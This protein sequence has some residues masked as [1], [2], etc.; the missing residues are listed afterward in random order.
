M[1]EPRGEGGRC[2]LLFLLF[3]LRFVF[4]RIVFVDDNDIVQIELQAFHDVE[5]FAS[6]GWTRVVDVGLFGLQR[7]RES[8]H[9]LR[10][11]T[12]A[13]DIDGDGAEL[14]TA[15]IAEKFLIRNDCGKVKYILEKI[16]PK[17]AKTVRTC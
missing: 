10:F 14:A 15:M 9:Q 17:T 3:L 2:Y 4:R 16:W 12:C 13:G 1:G 7:F 8:C 5:I 11:D 6:L